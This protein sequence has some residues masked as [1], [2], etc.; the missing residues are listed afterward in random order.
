LAAGFAGIQGGGSGE[1]EGS[2]GGFD[3]ASPAAPS[4]PPVPDPELD[5]EIKTREATRLRLQEVKLGLVIY[6]SERASFPSVL[7]ELLTP[8]QAFPR[9][10][11]NSDTLPIDGWGNTLHYSAQPGGAAFRL[12]SS[13]PDGVSNGGDGD[14]I[15]SP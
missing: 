8:T 2:S 12:W 4:S 10:F 6:K 14:D 7:S 15:L 1:Q 5:A 3:V 11:L 13:G 9:G